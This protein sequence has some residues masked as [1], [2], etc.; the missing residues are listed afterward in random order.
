M[1]ERCFW[2]LREAQLAMR[3]FP[4]V[5][6]RKLPECTSTKVFTG[7]LTWLH[8]AAKANNLGACKALLDGAFV[9][10]RPRDNARCEPYQ[11]ATCPK[12]DHFL[13]SRIPIATTRFGS[14]NARQEAEMDKDGVGDKDDA[15]L[16][17]VEEA[18]LF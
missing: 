10:S 3:I 17:L 7:G 8:L 11:H 18:L 12:V 1:K 13:R 9:D 2:E 4:A 15:V 14:G 5:V 16:G 6:W